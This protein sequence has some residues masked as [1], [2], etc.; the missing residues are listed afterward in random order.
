MRR[1]PDV[2]YARQDLYTI[3]PAI[4]ARLLRVPLVIEVN[5]E[6]GEELEIA[7]T[8]ASARRIAAWCERSSARAASR[9]LVLGERL[10]QE[11]R[12]RTGIPSERIA[13]TPIATHIPARHDPVAIRGSLSVDPSTFIAGFAGN[14]RPVQGVSVL[15][16]A[17]ARLDLPD[18]ELWII[19]TGAHDAILRRHAERMGQGPIR[20]FGGLPREDADRLLAACQI[21][22][23]P[24]IREEYDKIAGGPI[25]TKVLTYLASDRPVLI[26]DIPYYEWIERIGAGVSFRSGDVEALADCIRLWHTRW[27]DAGAPLDDW[28]W[29]SPGPG[30][31]FVEAGHTWKDAA[32]RVEGILTGLIQAAGDPRP[33]SGAR[34]RR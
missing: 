25:S 16:D 28:P 3:A 19:G 26:S 20:F 30:R 27:R 32:E 8:N 4:V 22:V 21:L 14:L 7:G 11:V 29:K 17:F 2:I 31:A 5:S 13:I 33:T 12:R 6:I 10:G 24:F 18:L 34:P 1:P 15:L 23:A 9:V